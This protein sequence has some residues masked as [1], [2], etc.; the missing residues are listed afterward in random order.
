MTRALV[1]T[2][3]GNLVRAAVSLLAIFSMCNS[4][5]AQCNS[6]SSAA[7]QSTNGSVQMHA[8]ST[9]INCTDRR[10]YV[11]AWISNLAFACYSGSRS[12]SFCVDYPTSGNA[13]TTIGGLECGAW[14]GH[15]RHHY[16]QSGTWIDLPNRDPVLY[17]GDCEVIACQ[18]MGPDYYWN[19]SECVYTPGSPIVIATGKGAVYSFTSAA[20]GLVFDID[21]D[22]D[23]EQVAWTSANSD[24][25]FLALDRDGDGRITSGKELFGNHT[26]PGSPNGFDALMKTAM[27]SNGGVLRG[28]VSSDDPVYAS[29]LLWTDRNHNGLSE[30]TELRPAS[31]LLSEIGLGYGL[32]M[33][34]DG[35]GN[36]FR[37]RGWATIRTA[38][39]RNAASGPDEE[40]LRKRVIYDVFLDIL[41]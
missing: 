37:F 4:A 39:G 3:R 32:H 33:R 23:V 20:Q 8:V 38:P 12:G 16:V 14:N 17:A 36:M 25:A 2:L 15:S 6:T 28:S 13:S 29:L 11:S 1:H 41:N 40:K 26:L 19:G 30:A 24:V 9:Q 35:V 5:W 34:R 21:G 7:D 10:M 18:Q 31:E 22:G 27:A